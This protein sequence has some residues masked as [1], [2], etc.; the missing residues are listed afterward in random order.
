MVIMRTCTL[1]RPKI[2]EQRSE[3]AKHMKEA[4]IVCSPHYVPL[5]HRPIF[6][7]IGR[8]V[9]DDVYTTAE[10]DRLIRLPLYNDMTPQEQNSVIMETKKILYWIM[11]KRKSMAMYL[12]KMVLLVVT[13]LNL[14]KEVLRRNSLIHCC[15]TRMGRFRR[16]LTMPVAKARLNL[17]HLRVQPSP[18]MYYVRFTV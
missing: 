16:T 5:H 6:K 4:G 17:G 3:F 13:V 11:K 10:S 18:L 15:I 8:F 2:G 12:S 1:S 7:R 14:W 9:G